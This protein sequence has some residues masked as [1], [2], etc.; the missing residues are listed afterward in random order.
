MTYILTGGESGMRQKGRRLTGG[1]GEEKGC[2]PIFR[3]IASK[4]NATTTTIGFVE[5]KNTWDLDF[6]L[7]E[8]EHSW[9]ADWN[10]IVV[11]IINA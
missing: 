6:Y 1:G 7:R 10:W 8:V 2:F 9:I 3:D 11:K 5:I 4:L